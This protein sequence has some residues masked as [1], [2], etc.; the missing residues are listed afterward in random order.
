MIHFLQ[1]KNNTRFQVIQ[2]IFEFIGRDY[3]SKEV[4][5]PGD[6]KSLKLEIVLKA[7]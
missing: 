5:G 6:S 3:D 1:F 7:E 4:I 2:L